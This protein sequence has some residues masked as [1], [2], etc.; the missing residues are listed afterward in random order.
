MGTSTDWQAATTAIALV[1]GFALNEISASFRDRRQDKRESMNNGRKREDIR[2]ELQRVTLLELQV[3]TQTAF[4][5][6][7]QVILHNEGALRNSGKF[8]EIPEDLDAR[9]LDS[10]NTLSRLIN[11]I[12]DDELR[13]KL[14]EFFNF[15]YSVRD[16]PQ[17]LPKAYPVN[18]DDYI[19]ENSQN[20]IA[21]AVSV[22]QWLGKQVRAEIAY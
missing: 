15:L 2:H 19:N 22:D 21:L 12:L 7:Y 4:K 1:I 10:S 3:V 16:F 13:G 17:K 14:S 20:L 6:C 8:T 5:D 11:R 9:F 18:A